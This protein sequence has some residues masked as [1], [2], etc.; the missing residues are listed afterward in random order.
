MSFNI[1]GAVTANVKNDRAPIYIRNWTSGATTYIY[2][3]YKRSTLAKR[4]HPRRS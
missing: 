4:L 3:Q 2:F 1:L